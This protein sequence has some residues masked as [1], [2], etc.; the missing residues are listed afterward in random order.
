[1]SKLVFVWDNFGPLH[2]DRCDAVA[3]R[4]AGRHQ[5]IGFELASRSK[6]YDW[7]PARG[8]QFAKVTLVEGQAIEEIPFFELFRKM[9][10]ACL[11]MGRDTHFFMCHYQ[12]PAIF[13]TAAVL[14]LAGRRVYAIGCSKFD[15]YE[16]SLLRELI[17]SFFYLPYRG[18]IASG[19]RSCDYMR[20]MG[21]RAD[22]IKSPYN[23]VSLER[24]RRL[25]GAAPAPGGTPFQDRHFTLVARLVPKKNV[26][27][28][29]DAFAIYAAR[30]QTP[31]E[32][33]IFGKGPLEEQLKEQART[34]EIDKLVHFHGFLQTTEI[35]QSYGRSLA[36][37]LPSIE[38]QF[39]NVVPE[40]MALGLPLI[41]SEN[42]GARDVL[43]QSGINGFIVEPDNPQG[44][45][46]FMQWLAEDELLW[47]KMCRASCEL[48]DRADVS[49]FAEAVE[50]LIS[51]GR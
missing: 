1:M 26:A 5:V 38:E 49:R 11:Q 29:L 12:E 22:R 37:L 32:L 35:S 18:G 47:S 51:V 16:R 30:V 23:S 31:R 27:M 36:L 44:M 14:R 42:C 3:R 20:F 8:T 19:K 41:L 24:I 39:G 6:V 33:H 7:L 28:A 46:N 17:K 10:R 43:L 50:S 13:A 34:A 40:A 4:C 21:L 45:A 9:L 25:S 2:A 48:A 15:D